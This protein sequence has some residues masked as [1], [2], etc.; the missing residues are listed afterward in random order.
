ME[1]V[2]MDVVYIF[3]IGI[4]FACLLCMEVQIKAIKTMIEERWIDHQEPMA[5]N[6]KSKEKNKTL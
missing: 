4:L 5:G 3:L 2:A 6:G 1:I